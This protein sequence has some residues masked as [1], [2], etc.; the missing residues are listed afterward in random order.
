MRAIRNM[1]DE[2]LQW[3]SPQ[4][5][6]MYGK[7]G[8]R[9][10]P[11][12]KLPRAQLRQLRY[13]IRSERLLMEEID[14]S[15]LFCWFVGLNLDEE[16]RDATVFTKNRDRLLEGDVAKPFLARVVEQAAARHLTSTNT[17]R[18]MGRC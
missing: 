7:E 12:E 5:D 8:R 10:I 2:V 15:V 3:L 9:S 13:S 11:A 14:Y 17:S 18:W 1:V 6:R 16:V 4:F